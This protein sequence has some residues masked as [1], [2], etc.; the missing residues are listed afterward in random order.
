MA[1]PD[2]DKTKISI[3]LA[4]KEATM[5]LIAVMILLVGII[6]PAYSDMEARVIAATS[7][8]FMEIPEPSDVLKAIRTRQSELFYGIGWEVIMNHVGIGGNYLVDFYRDENRKWSVDW[9][10]E[11]LYASYHLFGAGSF[12]DVFAQAGIGSAGSVYLGGDY[13]NRHQSTDPNYQLTLQRLTIGIFPYVAA[14]AAINL[15]G[16]IIGTKLNYMP[17]IT[18]PPVTDFDAYPLKNFQV[19]IFIGTSFEKKHKDSDSDND[20]SDCDCGWDW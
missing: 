8:P 7:V 3:L 16:L 19:M 20:E 9:F 14:G 18:P 5:R 13:Y 11:A 12:I 1:K 4:D 2:S 17:F 10:A 15:S 6:F